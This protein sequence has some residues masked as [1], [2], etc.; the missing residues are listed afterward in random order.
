MKR[1]LA[2]LLLLSQAL[3]QPAT[4]FAR[5]VVSAAHLTAAAHQA[6][7]ELTLTAAP[8]FHV[9]YLANPYRVVIDMEALDWR[10]PAPGKTASS[11]LVSGLRYGVQSSGASRLV[12]DLATPARISGAH[13]RRDKSGN[14]QL[15]INLQEVS[16]VNFA[17]AMTQYRAP[18][19]TT[20][21]VATMSTAAGGQVNTDA[22]ANAGVQATTQ[23]I[24]ARQQQAAA[25]SPS[26]TA[27][28]EVYVPPLLTD[29][30]TNLRSNAA[31]VQSDSLLYTSPDGYS[32]SYMHPPGSAFGAGVTV[33]MQF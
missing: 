6:T 3:L 30:D 19:K 5:P 32:L 12:L 1:L 21:D 17:Q 24:P 29:A 22:R 2:V 31:T 18:K 8:D 15:T 7:L 33:G 10:V 4:A 16:A 25:S 23:P 11:S 9:F 20:A 13:Y 26:G 14:M 28:K 27:A